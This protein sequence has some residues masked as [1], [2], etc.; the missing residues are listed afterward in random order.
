MLEIKSL[1]DFDDELANNGY[2][3]N[4][5]GGFGSEATNLSKKLIT[6][7]ASGVRDT[8]RA[9]VFLDGKFAFSLDIAQVVDLQVK[10]GQKVD[11]KRLEELRSASEFG[12]LYQRTLEWVLTRPH[13]VRETRDYLRRRQQKRIV[14]N[15]QRAKE[16]K[17]PFPEILDATIEPVI[18]RLIQREYLDDKRFAEYY[19]ENR[20]VKKG[21]SVKRL[22]ME[23]QKKGV[24]GE[25]IEASLASGARDDDEELQKMLAKKRARYDDQKLIAYLVR[26]GFDYHRVIK[27]ISA[28]QDHDAL[29]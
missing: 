16:G 17:K 18:E 6:K 20:F 15:R 22:R 19:I 13:S 12:K 5:N 28:Y 14:A 10:V 7:L 11:A 23:L 29:N 2:L 21:V 1:A 3:D 24:A 25:I 26:Q 9:N 4:E 8:S 27:A